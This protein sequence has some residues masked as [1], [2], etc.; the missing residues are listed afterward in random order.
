MYI[1]FETSIISFLIGTLSGFILTCK[2]IERQILGYFVIFYTFIQLFEACIYYTNNTNPF[3]T[4]MIFINLGLQGLIFFLLFNQ[5]FKINKLYLIITV[6]I[7]I[8]TFIVSFNN[9]NIQLT[10]CLYWSFNKNYLRQ[11]MIIMYGLML[12]WYLFDN[13]IK[14]NNKQNIDN[15]F[16]IISGLFLTSTLIFSYLFLSNM[17]CSPSMWCLSSAITAPILL[18]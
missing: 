8:Y 16:I 14:K 11:V 15:N 13:K 7:A 17:Q 1:D 4:Q 5:I 12:F 9:Q 6:I 2:T 10:S 18:L 3:L